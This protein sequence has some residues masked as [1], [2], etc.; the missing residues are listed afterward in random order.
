MGNIATNGAAVWEAMVGT[1][2]L[3]AVVTSNAVAVFHQQMVELSGE[4]LVTQQG[5]LTGVI[6]ESEGSAGDIVGSVTAIFLHNFDPVSYIPVT[7]IGD[8][9]IAGY[10]MVADHPYQRFLIDEDGDTTPIAAANVGYNCDCTAEVGNVRTGLSTMQLDSTD[11][12]TTATLMFRLLNFH[13]HDT[14]ATAHCR[15]IVSMNT[16][17]MA[18]DTTGA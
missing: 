8:G 1:P 10:V 14:V 13:P 11:V 7:T 6:Q 4:A 17:F 15:W 9:C 12:N 2:H 16:H 18:H 5:E 3:Y